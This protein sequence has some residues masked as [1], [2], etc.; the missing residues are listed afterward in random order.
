MVRWPDN[1]PPRPRGTHYRHG[2]P[3]VPPETFKCAR[4]KEAIVPSLSALRG[5]PMKLGLIPGRLSREETKGVFRCWIAVG[6]VGIRTSS[7]LQEMRVVGQDGDKV[8]VDV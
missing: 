4:R 5:P 1:A 8:D 7:G 2:G 6:S 3:R